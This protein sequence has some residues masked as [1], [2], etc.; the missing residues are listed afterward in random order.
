MSALAITPM[1]HEFVLAHAGRISFLLGGRMPKSQRLAQVAR[2]AEAHRKGAGSVALL[3]QLAAISGMS[4]TGYAKQHSLLPA[5]RVAEQGHAPLLHGAA[6]T[7]SIAK[8]VGARLHNDKAQLCRRCV[9]EDRS[10]WGFSWFRRTHNLAGIE[11]CPVH[12]EGLHWVTAPEPFSLLPQHWVERGEIE[13]VKCDPASEVE[14]QFQI[15]LHAVYELFLDRD[16]PF[17]LMRIH[18]TLARRIRELGLRNSREGR[19]PPLSDHVLSSGPK[20]WLSRHWPTL[21]EKEQ[22]RFY[23]PLDR[24][25]TAAIAPGSGFAYALAFATLFDYLEDVSRYLAMP[26]E[27]AKQRV[28]LPAK[29]QYSSEFWQTDFLE[30]FVKNAGNVVAIAKHLGLDRTYVARKTKSLGLPSLKGAG[31]SPRW[32]ALSRFRAGESLAAACAAEGVEVGLVEDLL[33]TASTTLVRVAKLVTAHKTGPSD[34]VTLPGL[35]S[36]G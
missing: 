19:K 16:R 4:V 34:E 1:P 6:E 7:P 36:M 25:P 17:E 15:R 5:L 31:S 32:R 12:G 29:L 3:E 26:I 35:A 20:A 33:R 14:R 13:S 8:L 18:C 27:R 28:E 30:V 24:L 10:H 2:L 21:C 23:Q 22:G 9:G 11:I